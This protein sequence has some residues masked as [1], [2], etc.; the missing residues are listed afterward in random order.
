MMLELYNA[1]FNLKFFFQLLQ[2]LFA[3]YICR[4]MSQ[5][6]MLSGIGSTNKFIEYVTKFWDSFYIDSVKIKQ[7]SVLLSYHN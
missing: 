4:E 5:R 3:F 7:Y 2:I 1:V 6:V